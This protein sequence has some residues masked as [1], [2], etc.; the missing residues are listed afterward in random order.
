MQK[1]VISLVGFQSIPSIEQY[2]K[3]FPDM[4]VELSYKMNRQFLDEVAPLVSGRVASVHAC[5]PQEP[6]FPNFGSHDTEVLKTSYTSIEESFRTA[7][8]FQADI[9]VLHPGYAT[10]FSIPSE[11]QKRK[12][13]LDNPSFRPYI[14]KEEGSICSPSYPHSD[15]YRS[16]SDQ[17]S[18]EL[19]KVA[20]LGKKYGVR[21]AVENLNP[22]VGYLFQTPEEMVS[23][24][25]ENADLF[26]CLDVGHLWI[27]SCLYGFD[28][29]AGLKAILDTQR[30]INCH[31]HANSS[32]IAS[33]TYV[34]SH[35]SLDR[36]GF[37]YE[38]VV[39]ILLETEAN[40]VLET[41][42]DPGRNTQLLTSLL[43]KTAR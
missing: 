40:L 43:K 31:L 41:V 10:D 22:R 7:S 27:S 23:L 14:F 37:P 18:K 33:Q 20:I 32:N 6:L 1:S 38:K 9:V 42:E 4:H 34:D 19:P 39:S 35:H 2:L 28:Y 26:L 24:T 30:V 15:V 13:L 11:N 8:R 17:A 16:H 25:K 12:Q 36:Y 3:D 29:F 21:L 5:C